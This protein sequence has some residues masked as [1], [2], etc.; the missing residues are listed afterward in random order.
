MPL[1]ILIIL[2]GVL[3]GSLIEVIETSV[4]SFWAQKA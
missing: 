1:L 3:L 2:G 4:K